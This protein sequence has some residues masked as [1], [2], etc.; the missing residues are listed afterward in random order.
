MRASDFDDFDLLVAMDREN[1]ADLL[2]IAP[3]EAARA[4]VRLL[5]EYD[6][7]SASAAAADVDVPDPY[8]GGPD[9]FER[10]LDVVTAGCRGLLDDVRSSR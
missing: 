1:R 2:A 6:P 4:K 5:R 3:D 8:Y 7:A 10:V 9:G